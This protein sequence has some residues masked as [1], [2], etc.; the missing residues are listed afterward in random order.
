MIG[1]DLNELKAVPTDHPERIKMNK[2]FEWL[3]KNGA[4]VNGVKV[5][6]YS[7]TNRGMIATK[8]FKVGD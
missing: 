7:E 2:F 1:E 4:K 5:R 6:W 8:D 3:K